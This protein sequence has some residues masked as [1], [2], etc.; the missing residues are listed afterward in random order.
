MNVSFNNV[1]DLQIPPRG[2]LEIAV[3][4]SNRIDHQR[5]PPR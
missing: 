2:V 4:I 1:C 3:N 5:F